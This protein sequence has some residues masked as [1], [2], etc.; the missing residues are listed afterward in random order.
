MSSSIARLL[1]AAVATSNP[2]RPLWASTNNIVT[3]VKTTTATE[4]AFLGL[5]DKITTL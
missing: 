1:H 5:V 3:P 2:V 4:T